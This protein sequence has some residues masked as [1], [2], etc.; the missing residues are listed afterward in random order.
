M[1]ND[2]SGGSAAFPLE[3]VVTNENEA[4][5]INDTAFGSNDGFSGTIGT[6]A[7][8]DDAGDVV[9]MSIVGGSGQQ[10]FGIDPDTGAIIQALGA[11]AG[12]YTLNVQAVDALGPRR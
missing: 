7:F 4:P 11:T 8:S 9:Q 10:F 5:L 6:L 3:I 2:G 12:V 1:A